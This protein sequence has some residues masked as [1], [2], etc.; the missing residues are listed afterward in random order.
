MRSRLLLIVGLVVFVTQPAAP[1]SFSCSF[2][3]PA[4]LGYG[5]NVC[6][7]SGKCVR[8]DAVC[9][10]SYTCDFKGFACKSDFDEAVQEIDEKVNEYNRLVRKYNDLLDCINTRDSVDDIRYCAI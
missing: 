8:D 6:S 9:F 2:G 5:E 3:Q 10:N 4:C 1:Q 7:S